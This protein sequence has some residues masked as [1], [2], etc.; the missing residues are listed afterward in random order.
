MAEGNILKEA[1]NIFERSDW[2]VANQTDK[3]AEMRKAKAGFPTSW[4]IVLMLAFP[5]G[6]VVVWLVKF[7]VGSE[8]IVL[9]LLKDGTVE[10]NSKKGKQATNNPFD[11]AGLAASVNSGLSWTYLIGLGIGLAIVSVVGWRV[12]WSITGV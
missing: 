3:Q 11:F 5:A 6:F 7:L 10:A 2:T 1:I 4:A 12:V 9:K 8:K